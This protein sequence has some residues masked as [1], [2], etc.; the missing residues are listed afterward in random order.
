MSKWQ[1]K[2]L[3][4]YEYRIYA[5]DGG[6]PYVIH[7]AVLSNYE[8]W[9]S[10]TWTAEGAVS[11]LSSPSQLDLLPAKVRRWKTAEELVQEWK[12]QVLHSIDFNSDGSIDSWRKDDGTH[13][14]K[15]AV[16]GRIDT[17]SL[18]FQERY[19]TEAL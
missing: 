3:G 12:D 16:P 6:A 11:S 13:L 1:P 10:T 4:G 18:E 14:R 5:E 2:T 15:P 7:G 8:E 19:T 17:Y 9:C